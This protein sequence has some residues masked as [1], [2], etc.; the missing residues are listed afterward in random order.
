MI[1]ETRDILPYAS[2]G[3]KG[4]DYLHDAGREITTTKTFART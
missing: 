1:V 3:V 2:E 4:I